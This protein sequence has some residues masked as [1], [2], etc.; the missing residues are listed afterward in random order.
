MQLLECF[1]H[2]NLSAS[3][4]LNVRFAHIDQ[5]DG[6]GGGCVGAGAGAGA[7]DC[8]DVAVVVGTVVNA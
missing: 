6:G 4:F 8:I 5:D 3:T 2:A 1:I 7:G